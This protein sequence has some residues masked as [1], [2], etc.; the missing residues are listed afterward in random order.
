MN[1]GMA[2]CADRTEVPYRVEPVLRP[3]LRDWCEMVNVNIPGHRLAVVVF[4]V[5]PANGTT[6]AVMSKTG[7]SRSLVSLVCVHEDATRGPF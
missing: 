7:L 6:C 4:E 5:E 3:Y 1:D 2:V